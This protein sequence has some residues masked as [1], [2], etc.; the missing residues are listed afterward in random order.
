MKR[1]EVLAKATDATT[2]R[3]KKYGTPED[4]FGRIANLWSAY[5]GNKYTARDVGIMMMLL[6]IARSCESPSYYDHYIDIAG[7]AAVT[8]ETMEG[9]NDGDI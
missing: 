4:N 6:K 2:E 9:K 5:N 1:N 7:Y 3:G 8:V